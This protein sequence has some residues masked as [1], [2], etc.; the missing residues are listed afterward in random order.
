MATTTESAL[1]LPEILEFISLQMDMVDL[2]VAVPSSTPMAR[3]KRAI[4][5]PYCTRLREPLNPL[6]TK[7]FGEVSCNLTSDR[8]SLPWDEFIKDIPWGKLRIQ[9][10]DYFQAYKEDTCGD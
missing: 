1:F 8:K 6:L 5:E 10:G 2:L 4:P 3:R 7:H 9:P